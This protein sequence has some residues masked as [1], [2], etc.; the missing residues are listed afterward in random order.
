MGSDGGEAVPDAAPYFA[1]PIE[2]IDRPHPY[3]TASF[4]AKLSYGWVTKLIALGAST[5]LLADD[6]WALP[7]TETCA[8]LHAPFLAHWSSA[9]A[10][11]SVPRFS[12]ALV[13]SFRRDLIVALVSFLLATAAAIAQPLLVQAL[14]QYLQRQPISFLGIENGYAL[15]ALLTLAAF[16]Q[17]ACVNYGFFTSYKVG[18]NMRSIVMDMVYDKALRLSSA[19]RQQTTSGEIVTLMSSDAE[20]VAEMA[21]EGVWI[22]A[23]PVTFLASLLLLGAFFGPLPALVGAVTTALILG[24]SLWLASVIGAARLDATSLSE[25]RVR[26]T[27]EVLLGIRVMKM[28]AWEPAIASRLQ[29][30]RDTETQHLRK[31]NR[32]RVS[33]VEFLFLSP[34]FVGASILSTYIWLG[35]AV[36]VT[37]IYTLIAF[38]NMSRHALYNFPRAIAGLSEGLGAGRRLDAYLALPEQ[39]GAGSSPTAPTLHNGAVSLVDAAWTWQRGGFELGR[40]TLTIS[41]GELVLVVGGVGAGKS[42]FLSALAGELLKTHGE[43]TDLRGRLAFLTQ[44]P[45]IRNATIRDNILMAAPVVD[46]ARYAAVLEACQLAHDLRLLPQGDA[47]EIGEQGV[48]LSGGQKARVHLA[49]ALFAA[50]TDVLLLDDPLSAVDVHVAH[51]IFESALL[52]FAHSKTRLLVLN[53][54]Y[55]FLPRADRILVLEKGHVVYDGPFTNELVARYPE[56]AS[57]P[58]SAAKRMS[59]APSTVEETKAPLGTEPSALMQ[60]EDRAQGSVGKAIYLA[61]FGHAGTQGG[62]VALALVAAFG[63]GQGVRIVADWF[64]GHWGQHFDRNAIALPHSGLYLLVVASGALFYGRC[65]LLVHF[66]GACSDALHKDLLSRLLAAPINLF[67]DVTPIGRILNRFARDLDIADSLLPNLFLDSLET[68]WVVA[69]ALVVCALASP[70]VAIA[71]VPILLIFY[72]AGEYFKRT[73]RELKRLEGIS[74]SPIFS[75]FAETLDGVRTIRALNL[76]RVFHAWSR[77]AVDANAKVLFA[78]VGASRWL[79]LRMDV[80]SVLLIAG[81][82]TILL[83]LRDTALSPTLAGL[84]LVYSL[85]LISNVQW[86]IR[87]FDL[88]ESAM[89]A[90]E[91]LLHFKTIPSEVRSGVVPPPTWPTQGSLRFENLHLRYRP[92]LPLVLHGVSLDIVAGEKIGICGRTGAGKSSLMVALFRLAEFDAGTIYMDGVDI[93]KMDLASLRRALAIIPQDPVLFSGSIRSNLDPFQEK[94]DVELEA[95][96]AKAHLPLP[97][98]TEVA[99]NGA[100]LSVGQRQLLCIGRALLRQSRVVVMDEATANVDLATD[101]LI[102]RT[103]RDAFQSDATTVLTIAHRLHTILHCDRIVV[104]QNGVLLATQT[105]HFYSLAHQ[106]GIV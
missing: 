80:I 24:G 11:S 37:Q 106:A 16:L 22:I 95:V 96:L 78:I 39:V 27:S 36:D 53:S 30:L 59:P 69:G 66:T 18:V 23:S 46:E 84:T 29:R 62:F 4:L 65:Q 5:P 3:A 76:E 14:L 91:R 21:N 85:A 19:A 88:T 99:E 8:G 32:Y 43:A 25:Q 81:I 63:L 38:T 50:N 55:H 92:E 28:Y 82:T 2:T 61:Y 56:Y 44:E 68:L 58:P 10:S 60:I 67:Y 15:M 54:H 41:P 101:A 105:S 94:L 26:V 75:S 77:S 73:S 42:S 13:R 72:Y 57:E 93:A 48:N 89:T 40:T 87:L 102:Q 17:A 7:A 86:A 70:Y 34:L 6:V 12:R 9:T 33:N 31:L 90:V 97:L 45:W 49:R 98:D 51:A 74:R 52:E 83:Q 47:T 100:N 1:L 20:R 64:Q 104:L 35:H 79:S 71:Y 103:I